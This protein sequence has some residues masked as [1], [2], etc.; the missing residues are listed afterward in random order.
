MC[1]IIAAED[2]RNVSKKILLG[3]S[4]DL[5]QQQ[6]TEESHQNT[7]KVQENEQGNTDES[8]SEDHSEFKR[9]L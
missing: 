1:L 5:H 6:K 2:N 7:D 8:K 3:S 9:H 4:R